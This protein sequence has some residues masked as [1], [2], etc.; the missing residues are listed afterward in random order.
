M[1]IIEAIGRAAHTIWNGEIDFAFPPENAT[2]DDDKLNEVVEILTDCSDNGTN[3]IAA[4]RIEF[5]FRPRSH[6]L[7]VAR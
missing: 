2:D 7:E 4:D 6:V 1:R 3:R 5:V